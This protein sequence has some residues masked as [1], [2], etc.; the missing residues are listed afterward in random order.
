MTRHHAGANAY[1]I[2]HVAVMCKALTLDGQKW[3]S[4]ADSHAVAAGSVRPDP[5]PPRIAKNNRKEKILCRLLVYLFFAKRGRLQHSATRA[6]SAVRIVATTSR[7]AIPGRGRLPRNAWLGQAAAE[8]VSPWRPSVTAFRTTCGAP[9]ASPWASG[10]RRTG[11]RHQSTKPPDLV[12]SYFTG[13]MGG[14]AGQPE[15]DIH[16]PLVPWWPVLVPQW[17]RSRFSLVPWWRCPNNSSKHFQGHRH[18]S[19]KHARE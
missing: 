15:G 13:G 12:P 2:S 1:T 8:C 7:A 17:R 5:L 9:A 3:R 19:T 4:T 11:R 14:A 10:G 16:S 6:T 18:Q